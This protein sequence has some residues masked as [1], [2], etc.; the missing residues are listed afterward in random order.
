M[1]YVYSL[2]DKYSKKIHN[3]K[4]LYLQ[5]LFKKKIKYSM[6]NYFTFALS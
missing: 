1:N 2:S 3:Q 4:P 6:Q 5:L